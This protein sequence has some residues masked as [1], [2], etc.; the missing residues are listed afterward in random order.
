MTC[1]NVKCMDCQFPGLETI[2]SNIGSQKSMHKPT[3]QLTR[4]EAGIPSFQGEPK[5]QLVDT[6]AGKVPR[7]KVGD[8]W[9]TH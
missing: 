3:I 9:E 7:F 8:K 2:T 6:V 5:T 1:P 4:V